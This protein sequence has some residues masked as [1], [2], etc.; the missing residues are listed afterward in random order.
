MENN[1]ENTKPA[2]T[3]LGGAGAFGQKAVLIGFSSAGILVTHYDAN[4]M[5]EM[6]KKMSQESKDRGESK[7]A[8]LTVGMKA[9]NEYIR[10]EANKTIEEAL[11]T[12]SGNFLIADNS[13]KKIKINKSADR[14]DVQVF[15][16]L[17][18]KTQN[19][20]HKFKLR[21]SSNEERDI[22]QLCKEFFGE[23]F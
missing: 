3:V 20:N 14:E 11:A 5:K 1:Y 6:T 8:R 9:A 22:K 18:V 23:K 19:E 13:I 16:T 2:L 21:I 7:L 4:A 15:Y 12:N 10:F 17:I